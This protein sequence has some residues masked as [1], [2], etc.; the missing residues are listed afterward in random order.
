M[1][2]I[3]DTSKLS[4]FPGK[5]PGIIQPWIPKGRTGKLYYMTSSSSAIPV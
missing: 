3:Q 1:K 2:I 5:M 4:V